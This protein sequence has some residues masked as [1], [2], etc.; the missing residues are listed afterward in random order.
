MELWLF[1]FE[2][3]ENNIPVCL[4]GCAEATG[5][6]RPFWNKIA[7]W[8]PANA[9]SLGALLLEILKDISVLDRLH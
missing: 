3:G 1:P 4:R 7:P 5:R 6:T 9:S 8:T 2:G